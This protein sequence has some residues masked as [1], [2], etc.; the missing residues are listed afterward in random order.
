[1]DSKTKL[2]VTLKPPVSQATPPLYKSH[3]ELGIPKAYYDNMTRSVLANEGSFIRKRGTLTPNNALKFKE[4]FDDII[5]DGLER[6]IKIEGSPNG[7][8]ARCAD[9]LRYCV[10]YWDDEHQDSKGRLHPAKAYATLRGRV[11]IKL[12]DANYLVIQFFH[13][14]LKAKATPLVS[15]HTNNT[16]EEIKSAPDYTWKEKLIDYLEK[17]DVNKP[18]KI[19]GLGLSNADIEYAKNSIDKF[20]NLVRENY[21]V[22]EI[23]EFDRVLVFVTKV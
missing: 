10:I 3:T 14:L 12:E 7:F 22:H 4:I 6:K 20:A 13:S 17:P 2:Q 8:H 16:A 1:M 9:A 5:N 11:R 23:V 21:N 15:I 19:V 18:L